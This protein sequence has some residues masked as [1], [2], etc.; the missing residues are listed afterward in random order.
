ML[1][2]RLDDLPP[3]LTSLSTTGLLRDE[4]PRLIEKW[5]DALE[6]GGALVASPDV[7][8]TLRLT[9]LGRDIMAGRRQD[10]LVLVPELK[11]AGAR[12]GKKGKSGRARRTQADTAP[13]TDTPIDDAL[14]E[15]LRVWRRQ[16]AARRQVPPYVILHDRTITAL[17]QA[18][19]RTA[20][21]LLEVTGLGP[22]KVT[23]YG[24]QLLELISGR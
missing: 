21:A 8:R 12:S 11:T 13:P 3:A 14:V 24:E 1:T 15:A 2:G 19:P 5:I 10:L 23:Q 17:A 16:E 6:G 18:R 22:A 4:D 9:A 20:D 7:Y